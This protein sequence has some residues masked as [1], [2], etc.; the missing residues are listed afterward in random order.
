MYL[1]IRNSIVLKKK[2]SSILPLKVD[3]KN[4]KTDEY[5]FKEFLGFTPD[6]PLAIPNEM[7]Y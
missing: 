3:T 1:L 5:L 2:S 6:F 4:S 7:I